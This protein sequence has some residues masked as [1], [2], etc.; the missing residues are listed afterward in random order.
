MGCDVDHI[1]ITNIRLDGRTGTELITLEVALKLHEKGFKV[2]IYSPVLGQSALALRRLGIPVADRIADLRGFS[3]DLIHGHHNTPL[4]TALLAFPGVPAIGFCHDPDS[5]HDAPVNSGRIMLHVA[6]SEAVENRLVQEGNIDRQRIRRLPNAADLEIFKELGPAPPNIKSALVVAKYKDTHI[7]PIARACQRRGIAITPVGGGMG[8]ASEDMP[9]LIASHD[10][11]FGSGRL[12]LEAIASR[13]PALCVDERGLAGLVTSDVFAA[14]RAR[15]FGG[16]LLIHPLEAES[17]GAEIDLYT[18]GDLELLVARHRHEISLA[19]YMERLMGIYA[20]AI[21]LAQN[22]PLDDLAE[23]WKI[24]GYCERLFPSLR[25]EGWYP[26]KPY[27][28]IARLRCSV[29]ELRRQLAQEKARHFKLFDADGKSV[30]LAF[31]PEEA[32]A[33]LL[34]ASGWDA[35]DDWGAWSVGDESALRIPEAFGWRDAAALKFEGE[36]FAPDIGPFFKQRKIQISVNRISTID[37]VIGHL[38]EKDRGYVYFMVPI[39]PDAKD[40]D[41]DLTI[42]IRFLASASPRELG[43]GTDSRRLGFKL[44]YVSASGKKRPIP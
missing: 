15:N 26:G 42:A 10:L 21:A 12:V 25:A 32:G 20:E 30:R 38:S 34:E 41:R 23:P 29:A 24:A 19:I 43:L 13:K 5:W 9:R 31:K 18:P 3:P 28:E 39:D 44:L 22:P 33:A 16:G 1:L 35:P 2:A 6:H 17:I 11:V 40:A 36:V 37:M 7:A 4:I 27:T 14:W 8:M